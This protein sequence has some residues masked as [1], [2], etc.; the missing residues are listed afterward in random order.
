MIITK[1]PFRISFLGGGTDFPEWYINNS[2]KTISTSI[3]KFSFIVVKRLQN[4][5]KY[6]YRLRYYENERCENVNQI[7]HI[8]ISAWIFI[9]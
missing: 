7:K 2:G 9:T 3:N 1:T 4:I 5:F 6:N 8:T